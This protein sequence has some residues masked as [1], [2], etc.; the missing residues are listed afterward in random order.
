MTQFA[1]VTGMA[2]LFA[3]LQGIPFFGMAAFIHGL[4]KD[5]DDDDLATMCVILLGRSGLMARSAP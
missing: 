5:D 2:V 3:G 4:F 1:G